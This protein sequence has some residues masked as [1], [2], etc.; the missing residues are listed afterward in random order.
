[1][2]TSASSS[3]STQG[4]I[5]AR[6][7]VVAAVISTTSSS[8]KATNMTAMTSVSGV[9]RT[10]QA[11]VVKLLIVYDYR[12]HISLTVYPLGF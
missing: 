1:M 6:T 12:L 8:A 10:N 5:I 7:F 11:N 3:G 9:H 2:A 4:L